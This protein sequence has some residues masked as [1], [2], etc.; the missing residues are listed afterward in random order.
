MRHAYGIPGALAEHRER[1]R[2]PG[3]RR[4]GI[5]GSFARGEESDILI[6]L[7]EG[8][9]S[10]D[11][12]MDLK[13]SLE[14]LFGRKVDLIDRDAVNHAYF[15]THNEVVGDAVRNRVLELQVADAR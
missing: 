13:F 1:I 14:D 8:G 15:G 12:Y 11:T 7:E 6:E 3:V 4:I 5:F 10:F 9:R 2:S